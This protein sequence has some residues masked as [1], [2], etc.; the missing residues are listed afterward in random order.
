[1]TDNKQKKLVERKEFFHY[2]GHLVYLILIV[3]YCISYP[4]WNFL[5]SSELSG[6]LSFGIFLAFFAIIWNILFKWTFKKRR[7]RKRKID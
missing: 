2:E 6:F 1:M 7:F 5:P 3:I 4:L